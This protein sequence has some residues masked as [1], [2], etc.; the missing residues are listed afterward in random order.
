MS[1][2]S[3]RRHTSPIAERSSRDLYRPAPHATPQKS[4]APRRDARSTP[5]RRGVDGSVSAPLYRS[6]VVGG[7]SH[8]DTVAAMASVTGCV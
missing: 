1:Q 6:V 4:R 8:R 5:R 7:L 2:A 3:V